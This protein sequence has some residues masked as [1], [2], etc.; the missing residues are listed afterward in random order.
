MVSQTGEHKIQRFLLALVLLVCLC[1]LAVFAVFNFIGFERFGTPDMYV[2]TLVGKLMWE[3]KTLFPYAFVFG[4]QLYIIATPVLSALFYGL[5]GSPNTA[6]ALAT[7]A[8]TLLIILSFWWMLRP[9]V[10][11]R[12]SLACGLL[13]LLGCVFGDELVKQDEGQLFFIMCSYY[14][15]YLITLF[16]VL[17]DYVRSLE[18][19]RLRPIP[20]SLSLLLCFATGMQSLRQTCIMVLPILAFEFLL[21]V[22]RAAFEHRLSLGASSLRALAY[23]A[24][25]LAGH[26]TVGLLD[27]RQR[28]I[29]DKP[30]EDF[31]QRIIDV[32]HAC[33]GVL[34]LGWANG[35]YPFFILLLVFQMAVLGFAL[36]IQIKSLRGD[37]SRLSYIWWLLLLSLAAVIAAAL[38]TSIRIRSIYLFTYYPLLALSMTMVMERLSAK[39]GRMLALLLCVLSLGNLYGSYYDEFRQSFREPEDS[40]A[41]VAQWAVDNGYE[42]VYGSSLAAPTVALY[43]DGALTAG[44][45][46]D[47]IML[48]ALEYLNLQNLYSLEDTNR[49]IYIFMPWELDYAHEAAENA[50]AAL[51]RIDE[52]LC[53]GKNVYTSDVQ[54]MYPRTYPWF[55]KQWKAGQFG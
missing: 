8:M 47:E 30:P 49:A 46:N 20:L 21:C 40:A 54:L 17:G 43:S 24:F 52:E 35:D 19:E 44:S 2:D 26:F 14:A 22:K 18:G 38:F 39:R 25:N 3:E 23:A 51:T 5:T 31:F 55:D 11:G 48:K 1:Y 7:T 10:K 53:G 15:C 41:K 45:W 33:R 27:V 36:W 34:G 12:L 29:F 9:F 32:L 6:M 13:M 50:G 42:L 28:T 16:V 37:G 4:N